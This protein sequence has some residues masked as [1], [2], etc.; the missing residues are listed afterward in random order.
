MTDHE[1]RLT[2]ADVAQAERDGLP[3]VVPTYFGPKGSHRVIVEVLG[4]DITVT[5]EDRRAHGER[6]IVRALGTESRLRAATTDGFTAEGRATVPA[7]DLRLP[8]AHELLTLED[9]G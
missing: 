5:P 7:C 2:D 8:T 9:E 1:R 3:L 6:W 4:A